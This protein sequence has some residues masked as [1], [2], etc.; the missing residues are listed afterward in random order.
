MESFDTS[1][2]ALLLAEP[3]VNEAVSAAITVLLRAAAG[4]KTGPL[5]CR[6]AVAIRSLRRGVNTA[7]AGGH[8]KGGNKSG[9]LI[10]RVRPEKS[11]NTSDF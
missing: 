9:A 2:T 6:P 3:E 1:L 8:I 10:R 4:H 5:G 7:N 11:R